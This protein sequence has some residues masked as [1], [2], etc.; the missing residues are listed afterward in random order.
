MAG[1]SATVPKS[2]HG[3]APGLLT[4]QE[5]LEE[6]CTGTLAVVCMG[7]TGRQGE[8]AQDWPVGMVAVGCGGQGRPLVVRSPPW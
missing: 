1:Q 4:R 8:Q 5:E 7:R 2:P 6:M 3:A